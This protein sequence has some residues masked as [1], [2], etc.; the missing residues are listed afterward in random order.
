MLS[1]KEQTTIVLVTYFSL[2]ILYYCVYK[3]FCE[4]VKKEHVEVHPY[5]RMV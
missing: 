3:P 2:N 1:A 5:N 4:C